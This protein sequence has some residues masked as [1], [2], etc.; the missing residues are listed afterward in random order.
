MNQVRVSAQN[1]AFKGSEQTRASSGST[2]VRAR[3][4][5]ALEARML[6]Q[7]IGEGSPARQTI[8]SVLR[9]GLCSIVKA[10]KPE[11]TSALCG[12]SS[13]RG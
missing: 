2:S 7:A 12:A 10:G 4:V 6:H 13:L 5:A 9:Q 1:E 11:H 8:G 3:H